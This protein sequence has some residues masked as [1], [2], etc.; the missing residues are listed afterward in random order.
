LEWSDIKAEAG[1]HTTFV[2][3]LEYMGG[4]GSWWRSGTKHYAPLV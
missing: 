1:G 3:E 4:L 2:E